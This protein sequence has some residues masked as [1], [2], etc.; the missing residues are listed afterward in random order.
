MDPIDVKLLDAL[1]ANGRLTNA[2]LAA[3]VGLSASQCSR[4]R[5]L[6]EEKGTISGYQATIDQLGVGLVIT[7]FVNVRLTAH[8]LDNRRHFTQLI[9]SLPE[10]QEAYTLTGENDYMLKVIAPSLETLSRIVNE[11]FL[12]HP[13]IAQVRSA[14]VLDR[15]KQSSRLPLNHLQP[16]RKDTSTASSRARDTKAP[17]KL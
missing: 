2:D 12:P 8:S 11:R 5:M 3:M 15:L 16:D 10:V 17:F 6:L 9:E 4:R 13:S 14:I 7:V 1:Q